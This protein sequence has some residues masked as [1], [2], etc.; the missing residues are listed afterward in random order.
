MNDDEQRFIERARDSLEARS[1][2]LSPSQAGRLRAA[3]RN[4][5]NSSRPALSRHFWVPVVATAALIV[6][7]VTLS[8][9]P[10]STEPPGIPLAQGNMDKAAG[11]FAML[12][13]DTPLEL[14]QDL[15]FYYWLEQGGA[16]AG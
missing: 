5:L 12:T 7:A 1:Q 13:Q 11:D 8:W 16:N 15:E 4:A 6:V 3:R 10:P 2:Q 14:Y 9:N